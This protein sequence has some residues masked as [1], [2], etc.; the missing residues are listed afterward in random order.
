M[1]NITDWIKGKFEMFAGQKVRTTVIE[2]MSIRSDIRGVVR[3]PASRLGSFL[4]T[5]RSHKRN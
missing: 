5:I 2:A 4:T 1:I 3:G